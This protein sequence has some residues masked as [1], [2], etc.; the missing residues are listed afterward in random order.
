MNNGSN[1]GMQ[2]N[3]SDHLPSFG[4]STNSNNRGYFDASDELNFVAPAH[5]VE[6]EKC[7]LT[8]A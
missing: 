2:D 8:V 5:P 7:G 6:E 4:N 3:Q 1:H